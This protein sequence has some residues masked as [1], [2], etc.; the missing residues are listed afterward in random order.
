MGGFSHTVKTH[1]EASLL[2]YSVSFLSSILRGVVLRDN[3]SSAGGLV[4][5]A[6]WELLRSSV[7]TSK[8][9]N[10]ALN[11]DEMELGV[12]V[13]SV[14]LE[15]LTDRDGLL[16]QMIEVLWDFRGNTLDLKDSQNLRTSDA[17]NLGDTHGVSEGDTDLRRSETLLGELEDLLNNI[18]R[19]KLQP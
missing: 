15:M 9:V 4:L 19:L 2:F 3:S 1:S 13:L 6:G 8:A 16:D 7:V 12:L 5:P 10:S 14:S 17:L 11:K 18:L